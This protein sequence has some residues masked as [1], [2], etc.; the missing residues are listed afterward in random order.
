MEQ[1]ARASST[2]SN[3]TG[4]VNPVCGAVVDPARAVSSVSMEG[5]THYFCCRGCRDEFDRDPHKYLAIA[6]H[7]RAP[8]S[9]AISVPQ[10]SAA[11]AAAAAPG[12]VT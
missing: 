12:D 8:A 2:Q 11:A 9:A 3:L 5:Q 6:A 1:A 10:E 4:Y 7:L